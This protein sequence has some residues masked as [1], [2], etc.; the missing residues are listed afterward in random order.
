[1]DEY[2]HLTSL[3]FKVVLYQYD[4]EQ[5]AQKVEVWG[6]DGTS[7]LG[8]GDDVPGAMLDVLVTWLGFYV[9]KTEGP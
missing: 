8:W 2:S 6:P 3:G 4:D 5:N 7:R 1:M 9:G